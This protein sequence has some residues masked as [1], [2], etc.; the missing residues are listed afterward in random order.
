M[1]VNEGLE[2]M[3]GEPIIA[4]FIAL[5]QPLCGGN[6]ENHEKPQQG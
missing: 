4:E 2:K 3:W 5:S 1:I 6:K